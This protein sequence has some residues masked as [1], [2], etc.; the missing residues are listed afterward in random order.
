MVQTASAALCFALVLLALHQDEQNKL[1][2][3]IM[4]VLPDGRVPVREFFLPRVLRL[5]FASR[6]MKTCRL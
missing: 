3:H 5:T 6:L 1:Y 4:Q 2:E